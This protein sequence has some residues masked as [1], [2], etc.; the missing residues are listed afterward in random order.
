MIKLIATDI[1]GTLVKDSSPE[2]YPEMLEAIRIWTD[3]G[4]YFCV[5]SGR[6]YESVR[7]MFHQ[8]EERILYLVENG[9]HVRFRGQ[10]ILIQKMRRD[11]A[12]GIIRQ[13]RP[14]YGQ[15]EAVISTVEGSLLETENKEFLD[16]FEKGYRNKYRIVKDALKENAEIIKIAIYQK[17]SIRALGESVLIPA[18]QDKVKVCM[19][20]EEWVDFMDASVDKGNALSF[21]QRY[22]GIR[23]E[24]TMAFG[25]NDNDIGLLQAAAES[26]A[27]ENARESIK[28]Q[29]KHICPSYQEK[30]VYQIV[31]KQLQTIMR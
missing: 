14:Y 15:C 17:D 25:D 1:D 31:A 9:A 16:F 7:K 10:D 22:L 19:A 26:Y 28:A 23:R 30:G 8:V 29:A 20:G 5:A 13:L 3:A 2:V 4:N 21:I 11:Y 24:E 18:W 27:V 12:E 6:Q